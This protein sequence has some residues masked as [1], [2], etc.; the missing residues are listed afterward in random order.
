MSKKIQSPAVF[1]AREAT[2]KA[3]EMKSFMEE[4]MAGGQLQA[5]KNAESRKIKLEEQKKQRDE[6]TSKEE[7]ASKKVAK[8]NKEKATSDLANLLK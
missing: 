2:K 1:S 8:E 6:K 4:K 7:K 5:Q 3:L